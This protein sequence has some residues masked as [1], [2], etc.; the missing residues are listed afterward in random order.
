MNEAAPKAF[1]EISLPDFGCPVLYSDTH[2]TS[3]RQKY[4]WPSYL[5]NNAAVYQACA[6]S[7]TKEPLETLDRAKQMQFYDV[8]R[9]KIDE[10]P[11][12]V[13]NDMYYQK[14]KY[15]QARKKGGQ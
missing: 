12:K 15:T 2:N 6:P 13:Y 10:S 7:F 4:E 1:L 14:I 8:C 9:D 3:L 11:F 5:V